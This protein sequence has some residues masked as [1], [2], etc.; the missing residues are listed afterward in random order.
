V[1]GTFVYT[2]AAGTVLKAGVQILSVTFTPTDSIDYTTATSTVSITVNTAATP[3]INW[4]T[5]AAI[6]YG[7]AL[8]AAQLNATSSVAGTFVYTPAAG[9]V[10]KAGVQ[11]LS[12][13]FTPTDSV[14]YTTATSTVSITVKQASPVIGWANPAAITY[15]TALGAAQLDATSSVAGTFVYTPAA[16]TVLRAGVQ[17]LSVTFTPTDSIDYT[18]ATSSI[19]ITVKAATP[20]INWATPAAIT[21]G[22]ALSATQ[23]DATSSVAGTFVYSPAAGAVL[24]VGSQTLSV[25]LTPTDTT[26]YTT[27]AQT[28]TLTVSAGT[29]TLS[30]SAT[31]VGFGNVALNTPATQDVTLSSTGT[32]PVTVNSGTVTGTSFSLSAP[33]LPATLTPG[34]TLTLAVQF[35]PTSTGAATGQLTIT[36][37]SSTNGTALIPLT[38]T[39]IAASYSVD[40][41]WD[42]PSSSPDPVAGYNVYRSPSGSSMYQLLNSTVDSQVTYVD[43]TVEDG[44]TYD[45]IV[46]SVDS[47]GNQSVPTSPIAVTI[48]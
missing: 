13:T 15:G 24:A 47:S 26:D 46:E 29:A 34:Q 21:Y 8:S 2:P 44:Q 11:T 16:G 25:T 7:T 27:A 12:V 6:T 10:L 20:V 31:S 33:A 30:I 42:A 22:T 35:D 14:D 39:G 37:T 3:V 36:S 19:S 17:I 4:A 23:L 38:G 32:A 48:P 40:L 18:T 45:Y 1:A 41:S 9:T 43:A 28:V 5:P